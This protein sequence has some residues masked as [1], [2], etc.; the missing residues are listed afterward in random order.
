[1]VQLRSLG[2]GCCYLVSGACCATLT[3]QLTHLQ[4]SKQ[5]SVGFV[6]HCFLFHCHIL[7]Q[8]FGESCVPGIN[9]MDLT[10]YPLLSRTLDWRSMLKDKIVTWEDWYQAPL[11]RKWQDKQ[12]GIS[13][14]YHSM[15]ELQD[16]NSPKFLMLIEKMTTDDPHTH[17]FRTPVMKEVF[18]LVNIF[19][20]S[21]FQTLSL[22]TVAACAARA[23]VKIEL[24]FPNETIIDFSSPRDSK[25]SILNFFRKR[26]NEL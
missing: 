8:H 5:C 17:A 11:W 15:H 14:Q 6:T 10:K 19:N 18:E 12:S 1:M 21:L 24:S 20:A 25:S 2:F 13:D 16:F 3:N 4:G 22:H 26:K 7:R 9:T 23:D